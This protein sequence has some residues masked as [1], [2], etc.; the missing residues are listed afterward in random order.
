MTRHRGEG[1]AA[2]TFTKKTYL[3][4]EQTC[5]PPMETRRLPAGGVA[6]AAFRVYQDNEW[7]KIRM[8]IPAF[9]G[10]HRETMRDH[11]DSSGNSVAL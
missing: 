7:N 8:M 1:T 2:P 9:I 6:P 4:M 5:H 10:E 11:L 3:G